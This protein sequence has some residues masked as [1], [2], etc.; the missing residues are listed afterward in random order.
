MSDKNIERDRYDRRS[1][2]A[3]DDVYS[4]NHHEKSYLLDPIEDY[5]NLIRSIPKPL[6]FL[7]IGAGLG[8]HSEQIL[9]AGHSLHAT[10]ISLQSIKIMRRRFKN[11]ENFSSEVSDMECLDYHD[12]SFD[13]VASAGALSYG[14]NDK[15]LTEIHRVLKRGGSFIAVAS[16]NNNPIYAMNRY[17]HFLR[18]KRSKSTLL[19]MPN[20]KL[21]K[22]YEEHFGK[23]R[24]RYFGSIIWILPFLNVFI[25][26][27]KLRD[28]SNLVDRKLNIKKSA[29][30]FTIKAIKV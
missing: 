14:D 6:R 11:Y 24:I 1:L 18:G 7:E 19:R 9:K 29:F 5:Y 22:K 12:E 15:V 23:A 26:T 27:N 21:L 25:N 3:F 13:V 28:F 8:E 30:K 17:F 16:L 4:L 20:I 2:K 10:D